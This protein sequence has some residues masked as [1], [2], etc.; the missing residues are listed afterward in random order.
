MPGHV[1]CQRR[2]PCR[3]KVSRR[4][5][6]WRLETP[7][8]ST[9][10]GNKH[11]QNVWI[12][13]LLWLFHHLIKPFSI[14][15]CFCIRLLLFRC[16]FCCCF[17]LLGAF[18]S[19]LE[20]SL[21][22]LPCLRVCITASTVWT[23]NKISLSALPSASDGLW[24]FLDL[25]IKPVL[26]IQRRIT[27]ENVKWGTELQGGGAWRCALSVELHVNVITPRYQRVKEDAFGVSR[28]WK[29]LWSCREPTPRRRGV[30]ENKDARESLG[31]AHVCVKIFQGRWHLSFT[32]GDFLWNF[33]RG[34]K[35]EF[36]K[37]KI[38]NKQRQWGKRV[39]LQLWCLLN[40]FT[41]F[42]CMCVMLGNKYPP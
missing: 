38:G 4:L 36:F 30:C 12:D 35:M 5:R 34:L 15:F 41:R 42:M 17:Y 21:Y 11:K 14:W 37:M 2:D 24:W 22:S 28:Y 10:H 8:P 33:L 1:L 40:G 3:W 39:C 13:A 20:T 27:S 9:L 7:A 6:Q 32:A 26:Y 18:I 19:H 31:R 29:S 25:Y 16:L 23:A